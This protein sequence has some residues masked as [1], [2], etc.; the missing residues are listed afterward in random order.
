MKLSPVKLVTSQMSSTCMQR[1]GP[2]ESISCH[3]INTTKDGQEKVF[4]YI[5]NI[6]DNSS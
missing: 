4:F 5:F 1:H 3:T 2:L 6:R